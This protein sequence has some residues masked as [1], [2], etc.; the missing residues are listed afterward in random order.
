[1]PTTQRR[2]G[3]G[4]LLFTGQGTLDNPDFTVSGTLAAAR[5]RGQVTVHNSVGDI[6]RIMT[7]DVGWTSEGQPEPLVRNESVSLPGSVVNTHHNG[8][9]SQASASGTITV[10]DPTTTAD[11]ITV[12]A[13]STHASL[14][15]T[16]DKRITV[17]TD[18]GSASRVTANQTAMATSTSSGYWTGYWTWDATT[19]TWYWTWI[20]VWSSGGYTIS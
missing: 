11:P 15:D 9:V 20:W 12:R 18:D 17:T 8:N 3:S 16:A 10:S 5:L 2:C 7:L 13:N 19:R 4:R 14:W 6:T 1:M